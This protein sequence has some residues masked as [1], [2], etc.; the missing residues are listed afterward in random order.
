VIRQGDVCTCRPCSSAARTP[1]SM[2]GFARFAVVG[3]RGLL[4][5]T[6]LLWAWMRR[7]QRAIA[8]AETCAKVEE[9]AANRVGATGSAP[10][11]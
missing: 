2:T 9:A 11:P 5:P 1:D 6:A 7:N 10:Q 8:A 4:V 3:I